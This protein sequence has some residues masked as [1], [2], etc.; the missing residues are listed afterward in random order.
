MIKELGKRQ[1]CLYFLGRLFSSVE[2]PRSPN[3]VFWPECSSFCCGSMVGSFCSVS[4]GGA[5]TVN[6]FGSHSETRRLSF[7][8]GSEYKSGIQMYREHE[9]LFVPILN[10]KLEHV[11]GKK[12]P[13]AYPTIHICWRNLESIL[14]QYHSSRCSIDVIYFYFAKKSQ[15]F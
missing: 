6:N 12:M 5:E 10:E 11:Y 2:V 15:R 9:K 7:G 14:P 1:Q 3:P 4:E 13:H 8:F